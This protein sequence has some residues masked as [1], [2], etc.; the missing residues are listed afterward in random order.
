MKS[1]TRTLVLSTLSLVLLA[2]S[3]T[4]EGILF[5]DG[6]W[7]QALQRAA[8]ENKYIMVD[9]YTD[10][11]GW[12]KVMDRETFSDPAV[13][14]V[15]NEHFIPVKIDFEK[16]VGI[17][18]GMK[19]RVNS[20]PTILFFN[21]A[22]QLVH[23]E[24]GYSE[25]NQVFIDA[26]NTALAIKEDRVF[27]FDSRDMNVAFPEFYK[28]SFQVGDN[29]SWPE[30]EE[31]VAYLDSQEDLFTEE[32]W[33]VLWRFQGND[34]YRMHVLE[35]IG[36]YGE[37]YGKSSA[38]G[39]GQSILQYKV[40]LASQEKSEEALNDALALLDRYDMG[41]ENIEQAKLRLQQMYYQRV[42]DWK[43]Y[44]RVSLAMIETTE[45]NAGEIN[46]I[47]WTLYEKSDD[48]E[49][50]KKAVEWMKPVIKQEPDNYAYLD[51]YAALCYKTNSLDDALMFANLAI[52]K[53]E[54]AEE[55][56]SSTVELLK[57]IKEARGEL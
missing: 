5:Y 49:L 40:Y 51:T 50:L 30:E 3:A 7:D 42:E 2:G 43:K 48:Q 18:L 39:A 25:D 20:Y 31:V 47:C 10:W 23:V 8:R 28:A 17:D 46:S 29:R 44:A 1:A 41:I 57:K 56:V 55:D 15:V 11:C 22:G 52:E 36:R 16:G 37:L 26:C 13:A 6:T 38:E 9:A 45:D 34:K 54:A 24:N 4:A 33:S 21:P 35:N 12:C 32:N 14:A 27:A 19:F 53:G